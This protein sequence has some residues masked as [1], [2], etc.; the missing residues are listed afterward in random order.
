M[1]LLV[2]TRIAALYWADPKCP[3]K[4]PPKRRLALDEVADQIRRRTFGRMN[5]DESDEAEK[6]FWAEVERHA[7]QQH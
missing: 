5:G 2:A 4:C 7:K 3:P 6:A 1:L